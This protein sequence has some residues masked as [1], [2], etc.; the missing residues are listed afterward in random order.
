[1][2]LANGH[3][4]LAGWVCYQMTLSAS[5]AV[6]AAVRWFTV[7]IYCHRDGRAEQLAYK[8]QPPLVLRFV[9]DLLQP[10]TGQIIG[11]VAHQ[12]LFIVCG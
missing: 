6:V 1:V 8:V 5:E 4:G 2:W 10:V 11:A 9:V 12:I 7:I 3:L